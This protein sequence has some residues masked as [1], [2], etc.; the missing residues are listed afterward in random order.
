MIKKINM[1]KRIN[2]CTGV[3]V[4]LTV[5]SLLVLC[6]YSMAIDR[7]YYKLARAHGGSMIVNVSTLLYNGYLYPLWD[8]SNF[9]RIKIIATFLEH[10]STPDAEY[11]VETHT[12]TFGNI[13]IDPQIERVEKSVSWVSGYG[14]WGFCPGVWL[15]E[16]KVYDSHSD[17]LLVSVA[18]E[19]TVKWDQIV[20]VSFHDGQGNGNILPNPYLCPM[21]Y[22]NTLGLESVSYSPETY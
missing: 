16:V 6:S 10:D 12:K 15:V 1:I 7:T 21:A 22:L 18:E 2:T 13:F 14:D 5:C 17:E 9:Y 8:G 3:M 4:A 19:V 11:T 20:E